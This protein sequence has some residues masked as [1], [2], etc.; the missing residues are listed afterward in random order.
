MPK[1]LWSKAKAAFSDT[2]PMSTLPM[3]PPGEEQA[4][5]ATAPQ[6]LVRV[7]ADIAGPRNTLHE[8]MAEIRKN[9]RVCPQP[10]RW[11]EFYQLLE[12]LG[13]GATPPPSPLVGPAW[14]TTPALA[15]RMCFREQ[16]EWA[17]AHNC[18]I[19]AFTF[20]KVLPDADWHYM[21]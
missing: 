5:A 11:T 10:Q 17:A 7:V 8:L 21:G 12:E 4:Y 1:S 15:K 6:P 18:I 3:I 14:S 13:D 19:A 20:L 16:V 9:N 2:E